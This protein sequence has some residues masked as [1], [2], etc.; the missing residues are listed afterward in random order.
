MVMPSIS[1]SSRMLGWLLLLSSMIVIAQTA[2]DRLGASR[3]FDDVHMNQIQEDTGLWRKAPEPDVDNQWR[4]APS[5]PMERDSRVTWGYDSSYEELRSR[6]NERDGATGY[7]YNFG[8]ERTG[9]LLRFN[10]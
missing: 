9:S 8:E 1:L 6:T 4:V 2:T 7:N 5:K 10:F 3:E